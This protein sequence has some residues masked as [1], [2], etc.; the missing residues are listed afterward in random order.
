MRQYQRLLKKVSS[1]MVAY[2]VVVVVA[3]IGMASKRHQVLWLRYDKTNEENKKQ[4]R[5][6]KNIK[7]TDLNTT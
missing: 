1:T 5:S 7:I 4:K 2:F 3:V 6:E